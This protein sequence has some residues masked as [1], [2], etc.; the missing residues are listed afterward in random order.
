MQHFNAAIDSDELSEQQTPWIGRIRVVRS[1]VVLSRVTVPPCRAPVFGLDTGPL[2]LVMNL[3][4]VFISY[5]MIW[6]NVTLL[7]L[8]FSNCLVAGRLSCQYHAVL[9]RC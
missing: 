1:E 8:S 4:V 2:W 3:F 6:K 9:E 5:C 7:C